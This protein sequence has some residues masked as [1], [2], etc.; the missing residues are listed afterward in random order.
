MLPSEVADFIGLTTGNS[1]TVGGTPAFGF[2]SSAFPSSLGDF[3]LHFICFPP[4]EDVERKMTHTKPKTQNETPT[5]KAE[6]S[7]LEN[8]V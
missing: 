4:T 7:R 3:R 1:A 8:F 6:A 2:W 5:I